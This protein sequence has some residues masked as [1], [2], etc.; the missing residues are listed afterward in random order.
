[1]GISAYM[2]L[3]TKHKIISYILFSGVNTYWAIIAYGKE[4]KILAIMLLVY[5][6]FC[7]RNI[8]TIRKSYDKRRVRKSLGK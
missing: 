2:L 6:V 1:M 8:N 3:E 4:E 7:I 5:N